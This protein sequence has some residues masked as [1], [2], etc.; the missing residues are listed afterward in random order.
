MQ[1]AM[2]Q[3]SDQR[4]PTRRAVRISLML[5]AAVLLYSVAITLLVLP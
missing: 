5:I 3:M 2:Q 4:V 1:H